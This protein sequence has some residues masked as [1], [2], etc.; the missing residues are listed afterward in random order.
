M[1]DPFT[2]PLLTADEAARHLQLPVT[3]LREWTKAELA[4]ALCDRLTKLLSR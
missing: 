1:A 4:A 3:T 2:T